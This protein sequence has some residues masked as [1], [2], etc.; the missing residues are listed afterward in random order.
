MK[1]EPLNI[2]KAVVLRILKED[3]GKKMLC[4]RFVPHSL[5]WEQRKESVTSCHDIIAMADTDKQF[6]S[7]IIR[8]DVTWCFA[9]DPETNRQSFEWVGETS[10]G[11]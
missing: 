5:T 9:F 10:L 3:W 4:A 1:A 11:R 2:P 8:V 7:N 6:L